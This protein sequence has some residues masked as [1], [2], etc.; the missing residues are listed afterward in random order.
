[1]AW[2]NLSSPIRQRHK[3]GY[4]FPEA[5]R[6]YALNPGKIH[7]YLCLPLSDKRTDRIAKGYTAAADSNITLHIQNRDLTYLAFR[8]FY[9]RLRGHAFCNSP[10]PLF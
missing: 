8:Y 9:T 4:K 5:A 1:M 2:H 7:E 3:T 6:I 10:V